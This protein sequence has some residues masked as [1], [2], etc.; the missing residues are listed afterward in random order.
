MNNYQIVLIRH[1]ESVWN[2]ENRFTGW[3]DVGLTP[4]GMQEAQQAA[5]SLIQSGFTFDQ[6]LTSVLR[7]A[8][9]T[10]WIILDEMDLMWIPVERDWRLNERHYGGLQGLNKAETAERLG[11]DLVHTWRRSYQAR[12]P[13]LPDD[14]PRHPRFDP[15]YAHLPAAQIP[16]CESLEDTYL[17]VRPWW[18]ERV[19]PRM[20]QGQRLLVVAH[21]NSLRA[22]VKMLDQISDEEIPALNIPTGVPLVYQFDARLQVSDKHYLD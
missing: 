5:Q 18:S 19:L 8:I 2:Q 16:A 6:A 17:R 10:L 1:G 12:P 3:T 20:L 14:D 15:R 9:H 7:R 22:L 4:A 11:K 21:G 13:A